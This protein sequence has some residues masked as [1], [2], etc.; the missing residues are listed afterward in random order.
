MKRNDRRT[1]Q[2]YDGPGI[3]THKFHELLPVVLK[4]IGDVYQDR[5]DLIISAWPEIIGSKLA[6]MT[7]AVSFEN[8]VL[9]VKVKN[10]TLHSLLSQHD[11]PKILQ[12]L[13]NK[14][15]K[16]SIKNV[17]FRIG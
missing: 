4:R 2:N 7:Q 13:R 14:F 10:S 8:G 3:T 5:P 12:S 16:S 6:S 15:P 17:V 9:Y 1:P 11:K